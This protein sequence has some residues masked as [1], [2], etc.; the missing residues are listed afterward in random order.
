DDLA[1]PA[2]DGAFSYLGGLKMSALLEA[3]RRGTALALARDGRPSLTLRVS[4]LDGEALGALFFFFEAAT[5]FAGRLYGVDAFGQ[6]G[7]ELG[8][9]LSSGLIGRPGYEDDRK[10]VLETEAAR[11]ERHGLQWPGWGSPTPQP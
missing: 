10:L 9:R 5:A 8:K 7:V 4:R 11:D 2:E 3:E 1:I 6:P